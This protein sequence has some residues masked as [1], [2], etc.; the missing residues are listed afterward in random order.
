MGEQARAEHVQ[1]AR[2][3]PAD[4]VAARG[5]RGEAARERDP[6]LGGVELGGRGVQHH[7]ELAGPRLEAL[8]E[9][10]ARELELGE[11]ALGVVGVALV[12]ARDERVRGGVDPGHRP[13]R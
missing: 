2:A 13:L 1:L 6:G 12:V 4:D 10:R 9:P 7:L 3:G 8:L 11:H 5:R